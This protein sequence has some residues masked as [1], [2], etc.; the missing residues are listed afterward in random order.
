MSNRNTTS[1]I[2]LG[3]DASQFQTDMQQVAASLERMTS[4]MNRSLGRMAKTTEVET[5]KISESVQDMGRSA[6]LAG[7]SLMNMGSLISDL[8]YGFRGIANNLSYMGQLFGMLVTQSGGFTAALRSLW[9]AMLGPM[10]VLLAINTIIAAIDGYIGNGKKAEKA[11]SDLVKSYLDETIKTEAL[12]KVVMSATATRETQIKAYNELKQ[13]IPSLDKLTMDEAVSTG[14]LTVAV[15]RLVDQKVKL[16]QVE[17]KIKEIAKLQT[18][19]DFETENRAKMVKEEVKFIEK[20]SNFFTS[21]DGGNILYSNVDEAAT[22]V[23]N[24]LESMNKEIAFKKESLASML[25]DGGI[26]DTKDPKPD[27]VKKTSAKDKADID[28]VKRKAILMAQA[29][30]IQTKMTEH[31]MGSME[32]DL[33]DASTRLGKTLFGATHENLG[34]SFG[35]GISLGVEDGMEKL[36]EIFKKATKSI[37]EPLEQM[38]KELDAMMRQYLVSTIVSGLDLVGQMIGRGKSAIDKN[39]DAYLASFADFLGKF[40]QLIIAFA[41][42]K[43]SFDS[44]LAKVGGGPVILAAGI[45]AV[46]AAGA[47]KG[48]LAKKSEGGSQTSSNVSVS[49]YSNYDNS[50]LVV[51]SR[52]D[53]RDMVIS[54]QRAEYAKRR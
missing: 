35:S 45:A 1:N 15:K 39:K 6:G 30:D 19:L 48:F 4:A 29:M 16:Y 38:S 33:R 22:R 21:T 13:L 50:E 10:G 44:L 42:A 23:T 8:P 36:P 43:I 32:R 18:T 5:T 34:Y 47:I 2:N 27:K 25:E 3:V 54:G 40:G 31:K 41:V 7:A 24:R 26:A 28:A 51:F 53:G 20:L 52:L 37:K 49:G 14:A 17:E 12:A 9:S 11:S 46:V